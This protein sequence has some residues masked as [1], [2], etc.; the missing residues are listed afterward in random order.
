M[1][2]KMYDRFCAIKAINEEWA[3]RLTAR[4]IF[5][6]LTVLQFVFAL[7]EE[8][9]LTERI[10]PPTFV[11]FDV[12]TSLSLCMRSFSH[13]ERH[14]AHV[15]LEWAFV[16]QPFVLSNVLC[17]CWRCTCVLAA[18]VRKIM[19]RRIN[20]VIVLPYVFDG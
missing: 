6:K 9:G 14:G 12:R 11:K 8:G 4:S 3:K 5:Q 10:I 18:G 20:F 1:L 13:W 7:K 19:S 16:R 17:L 2:L 15:M